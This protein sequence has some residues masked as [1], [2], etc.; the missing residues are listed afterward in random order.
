LESGKGLV[1]G[2]FLCGVRGVGKE[3]RLGRA[4]SMLIG[5]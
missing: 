5:S 3:F 4:M 2:D 1:L